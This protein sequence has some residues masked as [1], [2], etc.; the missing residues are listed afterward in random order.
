LHPAPQR[1]AVLS[2][3]PGGAGVAADTDSDAEWDADADASAAADDAGNA[4]AAAAPPAEAAASAAAAA[5]AAVAAFT[6]EDA[7]LLATP[8]EMDA[9][10]DSCLLQALRTRVRD[11]DLPSPASTLWA[12][13]VL[14]AR[15]AGAHVDIKRS[16][17]KKVAR[18]FATKAADGLLTLKEDKHSGEA[19]V[20]AVNRRHAALVAHAPHEAAAEGGD[21]AEA[22]PPQAGAPPAP[23]HIEE[24]VLPSHATR[25][26]FDAVQRGGAMT[27]AAA[28]AA[29]GAYC[30]AFCAAPASHASRVLLDPLLCDALF[31]GVIKKGEACPTEVARAE[32]AP[33][34]LA[35]CAHVRRVWR[36]APGDDAAAADAPLQRGAL[37]SLALALAA[38]AGGKR[39][40]LARG[41]EAF[42]IDPEA[43]AA[44]LRGR[45]AASCALQE[46]P[47]AEGSAPARSQPLRELVLQGERAAQLAQ[48]LE[49]DW[50]VPRRCISVPAA[51][52][53]GKGKK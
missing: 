1:D 37:P 29:L 32:L 40:T 31:K 10:I 47:R 27:A 7:A 15:P 3:A 50:G 2:L 17:Y 19:V 21:A 13:H 25:P 52:A 39:V 6:G 51:A 48:L 23:L 34:F 14:P 45:F 53:K 26:I 49:Q 24:L 36:G 41:F 42:C 44:Q 46:L 35:R 5:A 12:A 43:L 9:L 22:G 18:L 4:A 38:R 8:A 16:S 28:T 33:A 11:A 30:D 20:T